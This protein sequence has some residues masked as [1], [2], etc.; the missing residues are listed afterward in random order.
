MARRAAGP[1]VK[2]VVWITLEEPHPSKPK[3]AAP[4]SLNVLRGELCQVVS[5][6]CQSPLRINVHAK[7]K[8]WATR[9]S[10]LRLHL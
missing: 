2:F 8:G 4:A 3:G 9:Q 7:R 5:S 6:V 10:L 1:R